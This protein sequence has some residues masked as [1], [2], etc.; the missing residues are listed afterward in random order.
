L[1][2]T[3]LPFVRFVQGH[4]DFTPTDFRPDKLGSSH[5]S[6]ELAQ[7]IIYTSPFLCYSGSPESYLSNPAIDVLKAIPSTW[8]QTIVL[9][10]SA[11]GTVAGYARRKGD[12]WFI[13]VINGD[14]ERTFPIDLG[15]LGSGAYR[16]DQFS[17][18]SERKDGWKRIQNQITRKDKLS[19]NLLDNG[20]VV[21]RCIP[22]R[23]KP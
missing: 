4:A 23:A 8:D 1:H 16:I 3:T 18:T 22:L 15:F 7:A 10:G 6:H 5:W 17:D 11:I 14:G 2:D 21:A 9:P 12:E 20:G 19:P 13:G